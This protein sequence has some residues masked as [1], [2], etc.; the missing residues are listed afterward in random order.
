MNAAR[1]RVVCCRV[2]ARPTSRVCRSRAFIDTRM[3]I[4]FVAC[5]LAQESRRSAGLACVVI[6]HDFCKGDIVR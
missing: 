3:V 4:V 6:A 2:G 1:I 5:C